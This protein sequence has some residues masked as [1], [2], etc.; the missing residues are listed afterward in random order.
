VAHNREAANRPRRPVW[1]LV[2]AS[3]LALALALAVCIPLMPRLLFSRSMSGVSNFGVH[4][5]TVLPYTAGFVICACLLLKAST[6]L[7]MTGQNRQLAALCRITGVLFLLNLLSTYP[8][9]LDSTWR[10]V[11]DLCAI[12]LALALLIGAVTLAELLHDRSGY[13]VLAVAVAAFVVMGLTQVGL[14]HVLFAGEV[15]SGI[16]FGILLVRAAKR[17]EREVALPSRPRPAAGTQGRV[18]RV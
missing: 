14:L 15:A 16:A 10:L 11:H 3:Q 1:S 17:A 2:L 13:I 9:H 4:T 8:Y 6:Q 12:V 5:R 18:R 7:A